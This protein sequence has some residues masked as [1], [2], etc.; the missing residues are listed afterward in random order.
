M[1]AQKGC[2]IHTFYLAFEN[3]FKSISQRTNGK[4]SAFN[5]HSPKATDDLTNFIVENIIYIIGNKNSN[6]GGDKLI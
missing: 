5:V 1:L 2:P 3:D 6:G 4:S